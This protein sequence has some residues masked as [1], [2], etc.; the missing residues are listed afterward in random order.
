MASSDNNDDL[1]ISAAIGAWLVN[2]GEKVT[3]SEIAMINA[4]LKATS[5]TERGDLGQ[6]SM[7]DQV[8]PVQTQMMINQM[9]PNSVKNEYGARTPIDHRKVNTAINDLSWLL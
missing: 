2:G 3:Q 9:N 7:T 4:L 5:R 1:V 6:V 8:R